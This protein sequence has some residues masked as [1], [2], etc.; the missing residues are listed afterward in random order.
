MCPLAAIGCGD[1]RPPENASSAAPPATSSTDTPA[2]TEATES[3]VQVTAY[4][5][6]PPLN[7]FL[8]K[9]ELPTEGDDARDPYSEPGRFTRGTR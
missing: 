7:D 5:P 1:A 2:A 6:E 8:A 4:E 3:V 9:V